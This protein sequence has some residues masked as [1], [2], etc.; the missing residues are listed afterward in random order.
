MSIPIFIGGGGTMRRCASLS[1]A[2]AARA[3]FMASAKVKAGSCRRQTL[4][5]FVPNPAHETVSQH[6]S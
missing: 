6:V 2:S 4:D 3:T 1:A 5:G